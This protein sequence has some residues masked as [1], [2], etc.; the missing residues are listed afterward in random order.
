MFT[1]FYELQRTYHGDM[2]VFFDRLDSIETELRLTDSKA[3]DEPLSV[4]VGSFLQGFCVN[5]AKEF[6]RKYGLPIAVLTDETGELVHAYNYRELSA[7]TRLYLDARGVTDSRELFL[8]PFQAYYEKL[9]EADFEAIMKNMPEWAFPDDEISDA[10][11][12]W[13]LSNFQEFYQPV[14]GLERTQP[15]EF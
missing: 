5:L 8:E 6:N 2:Q 15:Y 14:I 13:L 3:P 12:N 9:N 4:A 11:I 7:G 1:G 10:M